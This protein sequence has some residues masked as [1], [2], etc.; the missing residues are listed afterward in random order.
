MSLWTDLLNCE[1][2]RID[3]RGTRTR[4][5]HHHGP[6]DSRPLVM[7]HGRGGHLETF[8]R[9]IGP[10][11]RNRDI[12]AIDLLG[13]G[14]TDQAGNLYDIGELIEHIRETINVLGLKDFDLMGQSLG[15]W[16]AAH[17]AASEPRV[18]LLVLIEPAGLQS[19]GERMADPKIKSAFDKGGAAFSTPTP[20]TV[21]LRFEQLFTDPDAIDDEMVELRQHLYSMANAGAVHKAVRAADNSRWLLTPQYL[22]TLRAPCLF[23][24]GEHGHTPHELLEEAAASIPD[25][26]LLT[27]PESKQWP[28]Y[29]RASVV[30]AAVD[31]FLQ[32]NKS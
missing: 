14:L 17:L 11:A 26:H 20:E 10:L 16:V 32:E 24:R 7:L 25:S 13:H 4:V 8:V 19:E 27:I 5:L 21:R 2:E 3:V 22:R 29:E 30:N 6:E 15:G 12:Y 1:V 18:K 28:H 9:N 23:I 31:H